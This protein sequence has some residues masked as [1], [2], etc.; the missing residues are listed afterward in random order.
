M[1]TD[2][3][4]FDNALLAHIHAGKAHFHQITSGHVMVLA[5][6]LAGKDKRGDP[7]GWRLIDRRLQA[8]RKAGKLV[9]D[10]KSGWSSP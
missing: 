3:S 6:K 9:Y 2:Y 4:L 5:D 10:R 7:Q 8:L 1:T